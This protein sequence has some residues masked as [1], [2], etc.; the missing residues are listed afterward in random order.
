MRPHFSLLVTAFGPSDAAST[1][2]IMGARAVHV[3]ADSL[4]STI[5]VGASSR[6]IVDAIVIDA[7]SQPLRDDVSRSIGLAQT[8]RQ[9][10]DAKMR[11]GVRWSAIPIIVLVANVA[12]ASMLRS[13]N[14]TRG[15]IVV[16]RELGWTKIYDEIGAAVLEFSLELVRQMRSLGWDLRYYR[17]RWIRVRANLPKRRRGYRPEFETEYYDGSSDH[18]LKATSSISRRQLAV[19]AF[20]STM[21]LQDVLYLQKLLVTPD[22][23]EPA[24]QRLIEEAPYLLRS[25]R[26]EMIARPRFVDGST[27]AVKYPDVIHHGLMEAAVEI[28]ELKLPRAALVARRGKLV[29]Q[30]AEI[31]AGVA[32]VREYAEIAVDPSHRSQMEA[33]FGEPV[34]V[35]ARTLIIGMAAGVDPDE[36]KKVRSYID[37]V[38]IRTWDEV[39]DEAIS[40]FS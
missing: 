9:I 30:S 20:D 32:Q 12:L 26:D 14:E 6:L 23:R 22:V 5:R 35:N 11:T 8:I 4:V 24:L 19:A 3:P 1:L 40:R 2:G 36:L 34:S 38:D 13:R 33:I 25:A 28:T 18:W 39:L 37:D 10:S 21:T 15:I 7:A 16:S 31:T 29:Y 17:G 27:G